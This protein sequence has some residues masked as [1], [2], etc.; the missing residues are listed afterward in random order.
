MLSG[1]WALDSY[2]HGIS[3][4]VLHAIVSGW[5]IAGIASYQTGQPYNPVV[6]TDLNNDGNPSNDLAP[7][8]TRNSLRLPSQFDISPRIARDI[9]VFRGARV[10]LIAEAFNLLNKS[11]VNGVNR[12]KYAF[13]TDAASGKTFLIPQTAFAFPTASVGPRTVQLAAKV[14]F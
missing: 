9:P 5:T 14:T 8:F 4:S 10:Q 6:N 12:T 13:A 2:T 3:N 11:N 7:G 1:V